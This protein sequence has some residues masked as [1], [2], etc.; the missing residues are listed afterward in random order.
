MAEPSD[1]R[2]WWAEGEEVQ[3]DMILLAGQMSKA[4]SL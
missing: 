3:S 4:G 2:G 1:R